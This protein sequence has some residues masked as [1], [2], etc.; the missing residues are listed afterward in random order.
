MVL[1]HGNKWDRVT[2]ELWPCQICWRAN[3]TRLA[4]ETAKIDRE[5]RDPDSYLSTLPKDIIRVIK[6]CL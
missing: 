3:F 6:W 4:K 2:F 1:V 5:R